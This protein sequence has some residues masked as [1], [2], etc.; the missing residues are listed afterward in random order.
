V[1]LARGGRGEYA[2]AL[3]A[4]QEGMELSERLGDKAHKG[5]MLNTL[6]WVY[7]EIYDLERAL[8]Y[9]HQGAEAAYAIG[10]PEIIRNAEI[11]LGDYYRLAGDLEQAQFYLE[12]VYQDI[13]RHETRGEEWMKW[14]YAQH[15]YHS[16][17]ELWLIKGET[18]PALRCAEGQ[19]YCHQRRLQEAEAALQ[20]ALTSARE[21]GNPPQLWQTYQTLGLL[22]EQLGRKDRARSAY[23]SA[24]RVINQVAHRLQDQELKRTF[25]AATPVKALRERDVEVE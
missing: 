18:V 2:A 4:L 10:D 25:L 6:G 17:G 20:R 3:R 7:G 11:N 9:N 5:R 1:G 21:I 19:V 22:C 8:R 15:L 23:A 14:R 12:K 16:L 24:L 13:Q